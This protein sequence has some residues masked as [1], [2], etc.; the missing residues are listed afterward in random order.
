MKKNAI[1]L[2]S[3]LLTFA[4]CS[5][6]PTPEEIASEKEKRSELFEKEWNPKIESVEKEIIKLRAISDQDLSNKTNSQN[7]AKKIEELRKLID[8]MDKAEKEML[9]DRENL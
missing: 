8:K 5:G 3:L 7:V 2:T 1:I 6:K 4:S 9:D